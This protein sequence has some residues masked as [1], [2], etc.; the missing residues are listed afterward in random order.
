M[1]DPVSQ[2][3]VLTDFDLS[4]MDRPERVSGNHQIGTIPFVALDLLSYADRKRYRRRCHHYELESFIWI[5][6]VVFLAYNNGERNP[7]DEFTKDWFT[8]GYRAC[9][10]QKL[11]FLITDLPSSFPSDNFMQYRRLTAIWF[12]TNTICAARTVI[13]LWATTMLSNPKPA[14]KRT[15]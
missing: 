4:T 1:Y 5:L 3:D 11:D 6:A 8:S 9:S 2:C 15:A 14:L 12:M 7:Q 13:V 10:L